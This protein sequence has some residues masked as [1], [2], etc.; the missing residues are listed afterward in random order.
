MRSLA[1][2]TVVAMVAGAAL[3]VLV[4]GKGAATPG[5]DA[6]DLKLASDLFIRSIKMVIGPI[7]VATLVLGIAGQ[8]D[9]RRT[10]RLAGRTFL[11]FVVVTSLALAIGMAAALVLRPGDHPALADALR[12]V[13]PDALPALAEPKPIRD[14]VRD[15][16]PTS[17]AEALSTNH[18]LQIVV[19]SMLFGAALAQVP[20]GRPKE[21]MLAFFEGLAETMFRL[22]GLILYALP[23]GVGAAMAVAVGGSGAAVL[24]PLMALV[25]TVY[26]GLAVYVLGVLL[27]VARLARVDLR[28]FWRA[29]REPVF[30]AFTTTSSDA[31]LPLALQRL[32]GFGVP[33]RVASFVL[34]TGL[35]FNLAGSTLYLAVATLFVAQAAGRTFSGAEL[36]LLFATLALATKGIAAVPRASLVVLSGTLAAF[37]L[38]LE[39]IALILGVDQAMDMA[40]TGVNTLG[41]GVAAAA[42]AR[43]EGD[44]GAASEA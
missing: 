40:R 21:A 11:Y 38:P 2:W 30:I 32:E 36:G 7:L 6:G 29:M 1:F 14:L 18:V 23:V 31:A 10:G 39:G 26:A 22:V 25:G 16:M 13:S 34:S 43:W 28:G 3:G 37:G 15:L 27:P 12:H 4:P 19:F 9:T 5:F 33:R 35:S 20:A 41:N 8:S 44:G 42:M 24:G 17:I